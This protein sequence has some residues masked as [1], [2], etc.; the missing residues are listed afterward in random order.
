MG[1]CA[2][3]GLDH[4]GSFRGKMSQIVRSERPHQKNV[5]SFRF[6]SC[7]SNS[8][9]LKSCCGLLFRSPQAAYQGIFFSQSASK[10]VQAWAT[11]R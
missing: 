9:G 7:D 4:R 1:C 11:A 8:Y 10:P 5:N 3:Q 6:S 2:V